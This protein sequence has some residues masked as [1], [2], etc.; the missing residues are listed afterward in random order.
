MPNQNEL[1]SYPSSPLLFEEEN[2]QHLSDQEH[3]SQKIPLSDDSLHNKS[4]DSVGMNIFI[5]RQAP[6]ITQNSDSESSLSSEEHVSVEYESSTD[7]SPNDDLQFEGNCNEKL[8]QINEEP[9]YNGSRITKAQ[10]FI[11]I[12][13]FVLRHTLT[14]IALS[15]LLDLISIHCP[16]N[17]LSTSKYIFLK[18]LQP[19]KDHLQCHIYCPNCEYYFGDKVDG[20]Q[21]VIC[22]TTLDRNSS[23]KNGNFF[24]YFPIQMQLENLLQREDIAACLKSGKES[25]NLENFSD[26]LSGTMYQNMHKPGGPLHCCDGISLTLNCDGV[27]VFKSSQY[28][29]WPLQG[30]I[31]ELSYNV[32]KENVLLFGL[33]FGTNKPNV[34]TFLKPFSQE[35]EKLS[36]VGFK[37]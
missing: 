11:L 15:D 31:N 29:I 9:L 3:F 6:S 19:V 24:I 34:N 20:G 23:L 18:D 13:S 14:G 5:T 10:S 26:V 27:P 30:I 8:H 37:S 28:S 21:C 33:W 35:C 7:E 1:D 32:R 2:D 36:A 4:D 16:E 12:L 17:S 22:N 25:C